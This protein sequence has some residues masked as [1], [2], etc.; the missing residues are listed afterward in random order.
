[1]LVVLIGVWWGTR[2][3]CRWMHDRRV[4]RHTDVV[5]VQFGFVLV[6]VSALIAVA[7][8]LTDGGRPMALTRTFWELTI[9]LGNVFLAMV[10]MVLRNSSLPRQAGKEAQR[11]GR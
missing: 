11:V 6:L 7:C 1:V 10:I 3:V 4:P 2:V 9:L 8:D 5:A